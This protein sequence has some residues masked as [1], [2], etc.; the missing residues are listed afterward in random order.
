M[1]LFQLDNEQVVETEVELAKK[2][3]PN[4]C[5]ELSDALS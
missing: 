3:H 2:A 1:F 5:R 4:S